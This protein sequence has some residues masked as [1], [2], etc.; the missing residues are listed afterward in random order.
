[1]TGDDD[2]MFRRGFRVAVI[3]DLK[4]KG[5]P[6]PAVAPFEAVEAKE[7]HG[8]SARHRG[9][10]AEIGHALG[11]KSRWIQPAQFTM[12]SSADEIKWLLENV[13]E[14]K[15]GP[16]WLQDNVRDE[17]PARRVTLREPFY[18]GSWEVT[19]GQFREFVK[20]TGYKTDAERGG[21]GLVWS[22]AKKG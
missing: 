16:K 13:A 22:V 3:G 4:P 6:L 18:L 14:Y 9:A 17:G 8:R 21:G 5:S 20:A 15:N 2:S 12:G 19:V 11:R 10:R 1:F 7:D